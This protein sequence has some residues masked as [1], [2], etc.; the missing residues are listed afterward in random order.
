M[1]HIHDEWT[2]ATDPANLQPSIPKTMRDAAALVRDH[3]P[4]G[5]DQTEIDD[6]VDS[7]EAPYGNRIQKLIRDAMRSVDDPRQS[8]AAVARVA[9]EQGLQPAEAPEP[10]PVITV[11]DIHLVCWQAITPD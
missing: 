4:P 2:I 9:E 1:D 8:A 10:L 7:L 6:L 11:D 5:Y 3:P